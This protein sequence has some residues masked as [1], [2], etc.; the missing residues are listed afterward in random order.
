[1]AE[2]V[3][4]GNK[5]PLGDDPSPNSSRSREDA[6]IDKTKRLAFPDAAI[7]P[8][9]NFEHYGDRPAGFENSLADMSKLSGKELQESYRSGLSDSAAHHDKVTDR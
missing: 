8:L 5:M 4:P 9:E 1:M 2:L 7:L 3:Q 6:I